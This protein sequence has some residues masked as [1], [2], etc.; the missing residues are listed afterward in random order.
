VVTEALELTE[1]TLDRF[2]HAELY[3]LHGELVRRGSEPA[4]Q[5]RGDK[6]ALARPRRGPRGVSA[7]EACFAQALAVAR[8]QGAHTLELRAGMS[9][10]RLWHQHGKTEQ[11]RRLLAEVYGWFTE[12]FDT[13][14]LQ[15]AQALLDELG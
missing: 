9:L 10:A 3:R 1:T 5:R 4:K 15:E 6:V 2:W 14:D 12:G 11:A 7:A 8:H 13:T